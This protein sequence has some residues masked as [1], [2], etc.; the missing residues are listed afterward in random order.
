MFNVRQNVKVKRKQTNTW[1]SIVHKAIPLRNE[2]MIRFI[3]II[4]SNVTNFLTST[5]R[6]EMPVGE[7][8][9]VYDQLY[10]FYVKHRKEWMTSEIR[11]ISSIALS[12]ITLLLYRLAN[13]KSNDV[14]LKLS[15]ENV[16]PFDECLDKKVLKKHGIPTDHMVLNNINISNLWW[17]TCTFTEQITKI[18]YIP[19]MEILLNV[20]VCRHAELLLIQAEGKSKEINNNVFTEVR[21]IGEE[22]KTK[23]VTTVNELY[24]VEMER[25]IY[26]LMFTFKTKSMVYG[27]GVKGVTRGLYEKTLFSKHSNVPEIISE[28][29]INVIE[30]EERFTRILSSLAIP[31]KESAETELSKVIY[32]TFLLPG[33][34]EKH[35]EKFKEVSHEAYNVICKFR[36][37]IIDKIIAWVDTAPFEYLFSNH[38]K[39]L[40]RMCAEQKNNNH[41]VHINT[42]DFELLRQF[43]SGTEILIAKLFKMRYSRFDIKDY[44]VK[45]NWASEF[46]QY[47][48]YYIYDMCNKLTEDRKNFKTVQIPYM[49]Q[50]IDE[51]YCVDPENN[52]IYSTYCFVHCASL[53]IHLCV[54][55][56]NLKGVLPDGLNLNVASSIVNATEITQKEE[57]MDLNDI[58][59]KEIDSELPVRVDLRDEIEMEGN[60]PPRDDEDEEEEEEEESDS[61]G[62]TYS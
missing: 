51:W 26:W 57:V 5:Q 60:E 24:L 46:E 13:F 40:K 43:D 21:T 41:T 4:D 48:N 62:S 7:I 1:K 32:D 3:H 23:K 35:E 15:K 34:K 59:A 56:P 28:F 33:E 52:K 58:Y 38:I 42:V 55:N 39:Q 37:N 14:Q 44:L 20:I 54:V 36:V 8:K 6:G 22:G 49:M 17:L 11:M 50:C 61:E 45:V 9:T 18:R 16:V 31:V 19:E 53:W 10:Q 29:D 12:K 47:P 27:S 2:E 25:M 30:M